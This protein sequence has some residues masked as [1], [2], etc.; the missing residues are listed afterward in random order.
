VTVPKIAT[1]GH[2]VA[3]ITELV[4]RTGS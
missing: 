4:E 1:I 2:S 3:L